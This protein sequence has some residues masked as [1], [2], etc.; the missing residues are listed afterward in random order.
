MQ[1]YLFRFGI[2]SDEEERK[3]VTATWHPEMQ[4]LRAKAELVIICWD[5]NFKTTMELFILL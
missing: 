2:L 1:N 3:Q 4:Q 5:S